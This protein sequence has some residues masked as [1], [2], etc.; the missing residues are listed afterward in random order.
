[1]NGSSTAA[2]Q[3][4]NGSGSA[5]SPRSLMAV[6]KDTTDTTQKE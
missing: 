6:T 2:A 1:M 4:H 5:A 3:Q